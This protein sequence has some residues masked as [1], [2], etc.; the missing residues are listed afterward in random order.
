MIYHKYCICSFISLHDIVVKVIEEVNPDNEV[1]P[2]SENEAIDHP[3]STK[4]GS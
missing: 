1:E 4:V 3:L 2:M